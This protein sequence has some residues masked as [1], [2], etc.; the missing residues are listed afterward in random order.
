KSSIARA[1]VVPRI[2]RG[3]LGGEAKAWRAAV[4][5][6]GGAR[7]PVLTLAEALM[8]PPALPEIATGDFKTPAALAAAV[9]A[10]AG[11]AVAPVANALDRVS[12][13]LR[14]EMGSNEA[15]AGGL[16]LLVDQLEELFTP[17]VDPQARERFSAALAALAGSGRVAV[18]ATLRSDAYA[19]LSRSPAILALKTA[20]ATLDVTTPGP[21][22]IAEIVRAPAAAAGIAFGPAA[23]EA[24]EHLE[25]E[26]LDDVIVR[27]ASGR[28]A[29]PLLQFTLSRLYDAMRERLTAGGRSI[30]AASESELVL[31]YED[32]Q[33]FGGLEGAIGERA[34]E[35]F[36]KLEPAA[37][38]HLPRLLRA[39]VEVEPADAGAQ[40]GGLRLFDVAAEAIATDAAATA[41]VDALVAARILVAS[42]AAGGAARLRLAHEAVLRT[43]ARARDIV[44]E[45]REFFRIRAEVIAAQRRF[46]RQRAE[47]GGRG[48]NAFLLPRG[49]PLA[50]AESIRQKFAGELAPDLVA[51]ID[52]SGRGA[53]RRQR[54]MTAATVIFAVM[55]VG[56]GLAAWMATRSETRA[57]RNF[58]LAI[59]QSDALV[60]KISEELKDLAVSR[61]ALRR[62]LVAIERQ[63]EE[64]ARINPDHPRLLLSRARMLTAFADN[65]L[66]LGETAEAVS[67]S[68]ECVSIT[69]KLVARL[70]HD[71]SMA[72]GLGHCLERLGTA[73]RDR[74]R[75]DE[76]IAA[77]QE[78]LQ[79]RRKVAALAPDNLGFHRDLSDGLRNLGYALVMVGRNDES[80]A[81]LQES[82]AIARRLAAGSPD[83]AVSLR[84]LADSLNTYAITLSQLGRREQAL[85]N[86]QESMRLAR[87][88]IQLDGGNTTWKRYLSN[89]LANSSVELVA[90]NRRPEALEVLQESLSLRR[91]LVALDPGNMT[92]QRELSYILVENASLLALLD[93]KPEA[94][95]AYRE[96]VAI[97]RRLIEIDA[98][99]VAWKNE[100]RRKLPPIAQ[101][102][103]TLGNREEAITLLREAIALWR[104]AVS[105]NRADTVQSFELAYLANHL[106][107]LLF[108]LKQYDEALVSYTEAVQAMRR[109]LAAGPEDLDNRKYLA[110]MVGNLG[111]ALFRLNRREESVTALRE[112]VGTYR[113]LA[114]KGEP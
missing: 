81:S 51:F 17:A 20:G 110:T 86:Y 15:P 55:A 35:A 84:L 113:A 107:N 92:W 16:V 98:G 49:V 106:G 100:L 82:V 111:R 45:H 57:S 42:H 62:V 68:E 30:G 90:L 85:A 108:E 91:A 40:G 105:F 44:A 2:L 76:S 56:A 112:V 60:S 53:R 58:D 32:Y 59:A 50:E 75:M 26:H 36:R 5:R 37:Q 61:D 21:A 25:G 104:D 99:N 103:V 14:E 47:R 6:P 3:A 22:E 74:G 102:L 65:Y 38:Q 13:A 48:A 8:A 10:G 4:M 72:A 77:Y 24:G 27:A 94:L 87:R 41:L 23:G 39:L 79:V 93:R 43:W 64:I 70:P 1:G 67:R 29:L 18:I 69:R 80:L 66:D 7:D 63:F 88:L 73:M 78:S 46:A 89:I 109:V 101:I 33:A 12:A 83:D 31:T 11:L 19:D 54:L 97:V 96:S 9:S 114:D 28:D 52:L 34:E 71:V 95:A